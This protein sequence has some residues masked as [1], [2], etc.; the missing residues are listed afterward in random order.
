MMKENKVPLLEIK[1]QL[2]INTYP[3]H[4]TLFMCA[5]CS[6]RFSQVVAFNWIYK[7]GRLYFFFDLFIK[8]YLLFD[9]LL[10]N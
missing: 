4:A 8:V 7:Y 5:V 6:F 2:T 10:G 3:L 1:S 9:Y